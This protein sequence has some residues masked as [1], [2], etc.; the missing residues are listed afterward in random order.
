ML[1]R[2]DRQVKFLY[3]GL[4]Q[5]WDPEAADGETTGWSTLVAR[6]VR[7]V[8]SDLQFAQRLSHDDWDAKE[9]ESSPFYSPELRDELDR[10]FG[11]PSG[12]RA[13]WSWVDEFSVYFDAMQTQTAVLARTDAALLTGLCSYLD[14]LSDTAARRPEEWRKA[15]EALLRD[16]YT[17]SR[18]LLL[19][20]PL[21]ATLPALPR[22]AGDATAFT[23]VLCEQLEEFRAR[24]SL[25]TSLVG[26]GDLPRCAP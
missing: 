8:A 1:Y 24:H 12:D 13:S 26:E 2:D 11:L 19:S 6:P 23:R 10:A 25:L 18:H 3:V 7:D 17:M 16:S 14:S 4:H 15:F 9:D 22:A 5:G 20:N 21:T